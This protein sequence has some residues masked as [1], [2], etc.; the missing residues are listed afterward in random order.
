MHPCA[1][2]TWGMQVNNLTE[3]A[4]AVI[5]HALKHTCQT[6]MNCLGEEAPEPL[7]ACFGLQAFVGSCKVQAVTLMLA[8]VSSS[9][10]TRCTLSVMHS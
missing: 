6:L 7:A 2:P 3:S 1:K 9:S 4:A 10:M 5:R 8:A